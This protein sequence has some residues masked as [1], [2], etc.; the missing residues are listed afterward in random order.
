[1]EAISP[2]CHPQN[3]TSARSS[4]RWANQWTQRN[5]AFV[6]H[7]NRTPGA[8]TKK[9]CEWHGITQ[10]FT[11]TLTHYFFASP[12]VSK[13]ILAWHD[14]KKTSEVRLLRQQHVQPC[15]VLSL[16]FAHDFVIFF[17]KEREKKR[18]DL[19]CFVGII[20]NC[21]EPCRSPMCLTSRLC[22]IFDVVLWTMASLSILPW[23]SPA[24][25]NLM[26]GEFP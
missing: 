19:F 24:A 3:R 18:F 13:V 6:G 23:W 9:V 4:C 16:A 11:G 2:D 10:K 12:F 8:A 20:K 5:L 25:V 26:L 21:T 17:K 22:L 14:A 15:S 7:S 1:M